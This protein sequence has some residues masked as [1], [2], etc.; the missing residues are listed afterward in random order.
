MCIC[1][2]LLP[3]ALTGSGHHLTLLPGPWTFLRSYESSALTRP[4]YSATGQ[5]N[6]VTTSGQ[7]WH[8]SP[9]N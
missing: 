1:T 2:Q 3:P 9:P 4:V 5:Q 8:A 6:A 7:G